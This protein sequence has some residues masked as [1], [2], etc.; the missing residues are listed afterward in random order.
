[1]TGIR[2]SVPATRGA[3]RRLAPLLLPALLGCA[4]SEPP[5]TVR[6]TIDCEPDV[7]TV[8]DEVTVHLTA[9]RTDAGATCAAMVRTF[10]L[11]DRSALPLRVEFSPPGGYDAWAAARVS[12]RRAGA[13]VAVRVLVQPLAGERLVDLPLS[14]ESAC[15]RAA[16]GTDLQCSGDACVPFPSPDPFNPALVDRAITCESGS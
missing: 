14:L 11:R 9:S 7:P 10:P 13:D 8:I 1:M 12:W 16:C 5:T 3:A 15:L 2:A 6:L 4:E